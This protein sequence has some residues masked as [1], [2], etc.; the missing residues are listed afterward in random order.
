M[1]NI[2]TQVSET[3]TP[4]LANQL[5][6]NQTNTTGTDTGTDSTNPY[7]QQDPNYEDPNEDLESYGNSLIH[8]NIQEVHYFITRD[9]LMALPESLLLCLFPSGVFLDRNGQIITNLTPNDEVY[10]TD[11]PPQC[12]EYIMDV[13]KIAFDDLINF[14]VD[15]YFIYNN[16][17]LFPTRQEFLPFGNEQGQTQQNG[18]GQD[19][20]HEYPTIIVLREDLDYYC[21]PKCSFKFDFL[22]NQSNPNIQNNDDAKDELLQHIM[23][24]LKEAAGSYLVSKTSIFEGLNSSNKL[25][26]SKDSSQSQNHNKLGAAEQHLMNMLCSSGFSKDSQWANRTQ[27][28]HKTVISSL[29]LCRLNNETTEQFRTSFNESIENYDLS[30]KNSTPAALSANSSTETSSETNSISNRN[31][32][33]KDSILSGQ[34]NDV[35]LSTDNDDD[36]DDNNNGINKK[37]NSS[38]KIKPKSHASQQRLLNRNPKLYDLIPKPDINPKLLL[39]WRKPA[40][41]CWWSEEDIELQ[42][43]IYGHWKATVESVSKK[44]SIPQFILTDIHE[45]DVT[46]LLI[47]VRLHIRRVWTLELNVVGVQ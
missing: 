28:Q 43:P 5:Y 36:D 25:K 34:V 21:V 46:N 44:T 14:P 40:R 31:S 9:Q 27:E 35:L 12:F 15:S 18:N 10:I 24:L 30:T 42:V 19:I 2:I 37:K 33:P 16:K 41:K 7:V 4:G 32:I 22:D 26:I 8:L 38:S 6:A 17:N 1:Q 29:S 20:L 13:Y 11:F 47:P 45:N 3:S 23:V 39:F